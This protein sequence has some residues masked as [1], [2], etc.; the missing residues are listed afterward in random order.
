MLNSTPVTVDPAG[1]LVATSTAVTPRHFEGTLFAP[2][3]IPAAPPALLFGKFSK[4]V[5]SLLATIET[6][7]ASAL[8][9]ATKTARNNT[10]N[11]MNIM[12]F[13]SSTMRA[14]VKRHYNR[15]E[16]CRLNLV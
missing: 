7:A 12:S 10:I 14:L 6:V 1:R 5:L 4:I 13:Q 3:K 11:L 15:P 16:F 9:A 8:G 2:E